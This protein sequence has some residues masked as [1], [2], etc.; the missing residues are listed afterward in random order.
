M[1]SV[2][3]LACALALW[4][5]DVV[6]PHAGIGIGT[7]VGNVHLGTGLGIDPLALLRRAG[8]PA[9]RERAGLPTVRR[10]TPVRDFVTPDGRHCRDFYED[11]A[12]D[13]RGVRSWGTACRQADGS[14]T[15]VSG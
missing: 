3:I 6:R 7:T 5:C 4:G 14:W 11:V 1:R 15:I 12:V 13:G 10:L 9:P 8:P 2:P